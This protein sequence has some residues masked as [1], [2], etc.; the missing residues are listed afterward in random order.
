MITTEAERV[1]P[2]LVHARTDT[3]IVDFPDALQRRVI[4]TWQIRRA[5]VLI[6]LFRTARAGDGA[7]DGVEAQDP[8]QREIR[9]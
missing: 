6:N 9:Q 2:T 4:E 8:A 3:T 7:T 1:L 5:D